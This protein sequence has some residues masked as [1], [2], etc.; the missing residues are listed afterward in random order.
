M[1]ASLVKQTPFSPT[2]TATNETLIAGE[3]EEEDPPKLHLMRLFLEPPPTATETPAVVRAT[4]RFLFRLSSSEM[5]VHSSLHLTSP[6]HSNGFTPKWNSTFFS[7][8]IVPCNSAPS[9]NTPGSGNENRLQCCCDLAEQL[10][11]ACLFHRHEEH[12]LLLQLRLRL[13]HHRRAYLDVAAVGEGIATT[14][15]EQQ[16]YASACFAT[17]TAQVAG[18]DALPQP[19]AVQL[20]HLRALPLTAPTLCPRSGTQILG[21]P[22]LLVRDHTQGGL[23][24]QTPSISFSLTSEPFMR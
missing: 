23:R 24:S 5:G 12:A 20:A 14:G 7:S 3:D 4:V 2:N 21:V 6:L 17:P 18:L 9:T 22:L 1:S 10:R 19:V 11:L 15:V 8:S 16:H 13:T